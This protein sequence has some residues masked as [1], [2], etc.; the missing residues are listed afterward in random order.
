[1]P[2]PEFDHNEQYVIRYVKTAGWYPG[3]F[4]T[5]Y[6]IGAAIVT[7]FGNCVASV[8]VMLVAMLVVLCFKAYEEWLQVRM[9]PVW[10]SVFAKYE[11][12]I[13]ESD[14]RAEKSPISK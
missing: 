6:L 11:A 7:G 12:A 3:S 8:E 13:E 10:R 5:G 2:L 1:M 9:L 4:T 14:A